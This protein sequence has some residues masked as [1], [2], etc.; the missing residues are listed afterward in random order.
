MKMLSKP[1]AVAGAVLAAGIGL[2]ACGGNSTASAAQPSN[3]HSPILAVGAEN[4]YANVIKQIGGPYVSV[5]GIMSNPNV[6]PHTYEANTK[7]AQLVAASDLVVQNGVG[8]DSFMNKLESGSPNSK[9]IVITVGLALGYGATTKNPHLFYNPSTMPKVASLIGKAL[10][11]EMPSH[12]QYFQHR[13]RIFQQS[14]TKWDN[15]IQQLKA[16]YPGAPVAVTEP[17]ADYMLQAAGLDIKTPWSFQTAIMNGTDPSPQD[18]QIEEN[19]IAKRQ[20]KVFVY[21]QQ[22]VDSTTRAIL[23]IAKTARVPVVGVYETMPPNHTYQTWME[24]EVQAVQ[25]ALKDGKSTV[26]M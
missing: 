18:V 2:T 24:D 21:N 13:V 9:R 3:A 1:M 17:V 19:L 10:S 25:E 7:D 16:E 4:E 20:V 23:A 15:E 14:L 22:A 12:K 26:T 5:T 6:D 11:K 8:Y